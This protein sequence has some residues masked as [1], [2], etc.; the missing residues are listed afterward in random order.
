MADVE[1]QASG[2]AAATGSF[3][4]LSGHARPHPFEPFARQPVQMDCRRYSSAQESVVSRL[5]FLC[6]AG[7]WQAAISLQEQALAIVND[8]QD[9][10]PEVS[11]LYELVSADDLHRMPQILGRARSCADL[12]SSTTLGCSCSA[13]RPGNGVSESRN[14]SGS[15]AYSTAPG[16][17]AAQGKPPVFALFLLPAPA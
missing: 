17:D 2:H 13:T 3:P 16:R 10:W 4:A 14:V 15:H 1:G 5:R 12:L 11:L 9:A 8:I 7:D 6:Q